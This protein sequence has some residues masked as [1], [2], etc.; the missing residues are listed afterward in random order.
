MRQD[1]DR[2]AFDTHRKKEY[3]ANKERW[4]RELSLDDSTPKR[5]RDATLQLVEFEVINNEILNIFF[6]IPLQISEG[7]P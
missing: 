5:Q 6:P 2:K 1:G 7:K 3:K 4:K